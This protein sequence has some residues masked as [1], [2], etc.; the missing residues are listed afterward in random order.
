[1]HK[2]IRVTIALLASLSAGYAQGPFVTI[3]TNVNP[4]WMPSEGAEFHS[5]YVAAMTALQSGDP[6]TA[7]EELAEIIDFCESM[8][9]GGRR[10]FSVASPAELAYFMQ[11]LEDDS[12]VVQIDMVCPASY[13][14]LAF[15]QVNLG[16][17]E[18]ALDNLYSAIELAPLWAEPLTELGY[19][20]NQSRQFERARETYEKALELANTHEGSSYLKPAALRGLGFALIELGD[21]DS[22]QKAYADSLEIEPDNEGARNE[23]LYIESLRGQNEATVDADKERQIRHLLE[24]NGFSQQ[25]E[26]VLT[27]IDEVMIAQ[28]DANATETEDVGML[29]AFRTRFGDRFIE[30]VTRA[31]IPIYD[32]EFTLEELSALIEFSQSA[33]GA[34]ILEATPAITESTI[35]ASWDITETLIPEILNE[36]ETEYSASDASDAGK[37]PEP[38]LVAIVPGFVPGQQYEVE[39]TKTRQDIRNPADAWTTTT[40][41][42]RVLEAD[43]DGFLLEWVYG[44]STRPES[45]ERANPSIE[46]NTDLE[47]LRL[48]IL[49]DAAGRYRGL[50]NEL[51]FRRDMRAE[52]EEMI[53]NAT[54]GIPEAN[55]EALTPATQISAVLAVIR[56]Y[57][58]VYG[59]E[60]E[61]GPPQTL[62]VPN[63]FRSGSPLSPVSIE[64]H[65][66][67]DSGRVM[68]SVQQWFR[69]QRPIC[70]LKPARPLT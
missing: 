40:A 48:E 50:D 10:V 17:V 28:L 52:V 24:V 53:Q 63:P 31:V 44:P 56:R 70:S 49:L 29:E 62:A 30:E 65:G 15:A 7:Q 21:L 39:I 5:A 58:G 14:M 42:V 34:R 47:G 2:L 20:F 36:L 22:A 38:S 66:I 61:P 33:A 9:S 46:L 59:L 51:E 64:L 23:L 16:D 60:I 18:G 45:P 25:L 37:G 55:R 11:T 12:T 26:T 19:L 57:F 41:K 27:S 54:L 6:D 43:S 69:R 8:R 4:T 35:T 68:A 67:E 32:R 3:E 1:M 13:K